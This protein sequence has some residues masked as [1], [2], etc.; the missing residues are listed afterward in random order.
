[1][2]PI[3]RLPLLT[4][5]HRYAEDAEW[6]K[7]TSIFRSYPSSIMRIG[8]KPIYA[9]KQEFGVGQ[10]QAHVFHRFINKKQTNSN[11]L[12]LN[13]RIEKDRDFVKLTQFFEIET[14][15]AKKINGI[16]HKTMLSNKL[17]GNLDLDSLFPFETSNGSNI[18]KAV[19]SLRDEC[20]YTCT[21]CNA[22]MTNDHMFKLLFDIITLTGKH[23]T[24]KSEFDFSSPTTN[25]GKDEASGIRC[26]L[27]LLQA[28]IPTNARIEEKGDEISFPTDRFSAEKWGL[29][30]SISYLIIMILFAIWRHVH[31]VKT[32]DYMRLRVTLGISDFYCSVLFY[33][34]YVANKS[35]SDYEI[36]FEAFHYI[37]YSRFTSDL[38]SQYPEFKENNIIQTIL[39]KHFHHSPGDTWNKFLYFGTTTASRGDQLVNFF[40]VQ[41]QVENLTNAISSFYNIMFIPYVKTQSYIP[42][43]DPDVHRGFHEI[44][45]TYDRYIGVFAR[46]PSCNLHL[47]LSK[48][49]PNYYWLPFIKHNIPVLDYYMLQLHKEYASTDETQQYAAEWTLWW[50]RFLRQVQKCIQ[51]RAG[52]GEE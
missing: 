7:V 5:Y 37:F 45:T 2:C 24:I 28:T 36:S 32:K 6:I 35:E 20:F 39:Q 33:I 18:I 11:F 47:L 9:R 46:Q 21:E 50:T 41:L 27:I 1:M 52:K 48:I 13:K 10:D 23:D 8:T 40:D 44:Y 19:T 15:I 43:R 49:S 3:C 38:G 16:T 26:L 30:A 17:F 14:K 42:A 34:L 31:Y 25:A 12:N 51:T 22:S 29:R 4:D